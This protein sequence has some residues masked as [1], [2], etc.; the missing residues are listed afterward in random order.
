MGTEKKSSGIFLVIVPHR[1]VRNEAQKY[2]SL[3][4]NSGLKNV[5]SF[6][7][8]SP[9][10]ALS[11][12][13]DAEELKK[14]AHSL[15]DAMGNNKMYSKDAYSSSFAD[16][17][18]LEDHLSAP[19]K[20]V[21]IF[22]LFGLRLETEITEDAFS[23]IDKKLIK[24]FSPL[25]IGMFLIPEPFKKFSD[26]MEKNQER[27]RSPFLSFRSCAVSNMRWQSFEKN[28][29]TVFIWKIEKLFWLPKK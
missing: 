24:F 6:P 10:A 4:L 8:V 7:L 2:S 9:V 21:N 18:N 28:G 25:L 17:F 1:D 26:F 27:L 11:R 14:T 16:V 3:L 13:L 23:C 29:E 20:T 5:Y 19:G 22:S 15:K 12:P